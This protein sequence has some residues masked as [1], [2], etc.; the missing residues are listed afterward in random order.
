M[1]GGH[2]RVDRQRTYIGRAVNDD[3]VV[4]GAGDLESGLEHQLL[5]DLAGHADLGLGQVRI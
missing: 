4:V 3:E 5:A 1:V 2:Q